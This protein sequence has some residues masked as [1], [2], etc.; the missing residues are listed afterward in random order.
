M[1][2]RDVGYYVFTVP[3]IAGALGLITT[4]TTFALVAAIGLYV[5]R[6][7]VVVFGRRVTVEP[8]ARLHYGEPRASAWPATHC[9]R[10]LPA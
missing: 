1:F 2:G 10:S 5:L 3:V 6:R 8:S 4:L 9:S 7:D